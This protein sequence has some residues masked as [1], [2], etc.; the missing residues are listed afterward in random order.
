MEVSTVMAPT[1]TSPPNRARELVKLM[2]RMLSVETMTK[3]EIPRPRQGRM[4]S[5]RS[6][7][8]SFFSFRMVCLPVRNRRIHR[9]LTAWL[10]IVARAAP[11]TPISSTK[12]NTGS[13]AMLMAAPMTVVSMLIL[14]KPWAVTKEFIPITVRTNTLPTI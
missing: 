14:A 9:A 2:E 8:F 4:M 5:F 3:V 7:M 11:V 1:A 6:F 13:R 10:N 12:M